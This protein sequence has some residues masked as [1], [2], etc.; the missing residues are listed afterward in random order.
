MIWKSKSCMELQSRDYFNFCVIAERTTSVLLSSL[1]QSQYCT[2]WRNDRALGHCHEMPPMKYQAIRKP[3]TAYAV[4]LRSFGGFRSTHLWNPH[5]DF[6]CNTFLTSLYADQTN[7]PPRQ[8][9]VCPVDCTIMC[10]LPIAL[11]KTHA[12]RIKVLTQQMT[13]KLKKASACAN[14]LY[15]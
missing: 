7:Q 14:G 3:T 5:H 13:H 1:K 8:L 10:T 12:C 6:I 4:W 9:W 11:G 2:Q 15:T